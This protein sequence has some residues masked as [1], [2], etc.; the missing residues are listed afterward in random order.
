MKVKRTTW[1]RLV[2]RLLVPA[3]L[4]C[5]ALSVAIDMIV[6]RKLTHPQRRRPTTSPQDYLEISNVQLPWSDEQWTTADNA[7][8]HGWLLRRAAGS[9]A[10]VLSHGYG[11]GANRSDLLDLGVDL[12]RSGFTVL[13]YDLRG[14]GESSVDWSSLGDYEADDLVSAI[15]YLKAVK[16]STGKTLVDPNRIGLYGVSIGG[17]ASLVAAS[18]DASVRAVAA[19]S[20][21]PTPDSFARILTKQQFGVNSE[22][23]NMVVDWGLRASFTSHYNSTSAIDSVRGYQDVKL[24]L[25]GGANA[26]DLRLTTGLVY[27]QSLEPRQITEVAYSRIERLNGPDSNTYNQIIIDFFKRLNTAP[28]AA[29]ANKKT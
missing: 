1:T 28:Q 2:L 9:P 24:L 16:D 22:M 12:W 19:D 14:H 5:L 6:V 10:I 15:T 26:T 3:I 17:Y 25:I 23:I 13:L 21:Y 7:V 8:S 27:I 29:E 18:R 11:N 4:G 20:V